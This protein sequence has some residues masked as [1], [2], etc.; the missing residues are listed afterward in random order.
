MLLLDA[1]VEES[2]TAEQWEALSVPVQDS[3]IPRIPRKRS[4]KC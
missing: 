1:G 4:D 3:K 2:L